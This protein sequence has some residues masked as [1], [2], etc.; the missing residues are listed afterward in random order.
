[1][2]IT[3]VPV[4]AST[5]S[6]E[7]LIKDFLPDFGIGPIIE[8]KFYSGGF[9]HTYRVK[10]IDGSTYYLRAYRIQWRTLTDIQYELDVLNHLKHKGFPAASPVP[11][12]D[13]QPF[14]SVPAPEGT[15]I[16]AL[17]TEAPGP[18]I[19][20]DHEPARN[21]NSY[22]RAVA[23][24][25]NALNDFN[26]LHPRF[27]LDLA[28]FIDQPLRNIQPFLSHRPDDWDF[29]Q[30]F[31]ETLR[32][33]ILAIPAEMLEQGFCHGDL[34]GYH[35]NITPNGILT[36]FDFDCGGFGYRAYD[37]AVFLWCCRLEDAVVARWAPFL[38]SYRENRSIHERDVEAIP[39]FVCAR[40]LWHMGVHTQNSLDW[41]I[42]FL[43]DKYFDSH[44]MDLRKAKEDYLLDEKK[45]ISPF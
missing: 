43:N 2:M 44:L 19:S 4:I 14:C 9:N 3:T 13:G 18:E 37:L 12:K 39:L 10:A 41:G 38:K 28:H 42:D 8:C 40:Y 36:F 27:H 21:A 45:R 24:M 33:R 22:G 32:Q 23:Q 16:L 1:M 7:A 5:L 30:Q 17:F 29:L 35:A 6:P 15:R 34:Q 26:S 20:Y 11:Y 25:H 31:A